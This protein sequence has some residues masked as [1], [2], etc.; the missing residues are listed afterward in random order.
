MV[1]LNKLLVVVVVVV[2]AHWGKGGVEAKKNWNIQFYFQPQNHPPPHP[3][4]THTHTRTHTLFI[5]LRR[6]CRGYKL[7]AK[8][9]HWLEFYFL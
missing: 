1:I 9:I 6:R 8:T 4:H 3:L 5:L 7:V 2:I